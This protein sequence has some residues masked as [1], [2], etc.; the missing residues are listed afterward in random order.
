MVA[1]SSSAE[2]MAANM[3]LQKSS[4]EYNWSMPIQKNTYSTDR[5]RSYPLV[6]CAYVSATLCVCGGLVG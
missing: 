5:D 4:S 2:K 3:D 6:C 1:L